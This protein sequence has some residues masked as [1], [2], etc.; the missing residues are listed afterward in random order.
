VPTRFLLGRHD[1]AL[2]AA[3]TRRVVHDRLGIEADEIDAGHCIHLAKPVELANWI[4]QCVTVP[5][6]TAK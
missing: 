5:P 4:H 1:R 3:V 2:P 6:Q